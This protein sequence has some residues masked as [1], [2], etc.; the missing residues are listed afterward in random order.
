MEPSDF[1]ARGVTLKKLEYRGRSAIQVVETA[2]SP[3]GTDTLAIL[4]G[5]PFQDGTI[6]VW[7]AGE[8]GPGADAGARGFVGIAFRVGDDP[9]H[10]EAI[11]LRPTNGRAMEQLR[12]NHAIQ[13]VSQ[14]EY[15]FDRLRSETPG[16]YES[17]ADMVPGQWVHCRIVVAGKQ[18]RLFVGSAEQPNLIV[19][20]L[21][22]GLESGSVALW[23]GPWTI[24]YFSGLKV[25]P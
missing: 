5:R 19:N 12:R 9:A 17:Y 20:D 3:T 2:P 14:P 13:Y 11:Y 4:K 6:D 1:D 15:P 8:P 16:V 7:L 21:K 25:T 22:H 18:A 24:A 10:Y 23:I